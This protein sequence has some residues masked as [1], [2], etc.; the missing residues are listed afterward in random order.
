M[1]ITANQKRLID[2]LRS[3]VS[4]MSVATCRRALVLSAWD[5]PKAKALLKDTVKMRVQFAQGGGRE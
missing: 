4:G 1:S 3:E 2:K 5:I